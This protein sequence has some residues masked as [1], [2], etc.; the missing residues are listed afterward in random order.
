MRLQRVHCGFGSLPTSF[1][2]SKETHMFKVITAAAIS[3][4]A[5][6]AVASQPAQARG[7]AVAAGVIGGLAAGAIIGSEVNR[8]YYGGPGYYDNG[9]QAV[10]EC[11]I[12][13]RDFEDQ[14]GRLHVRRVCD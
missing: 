12:E 4:L 13:R 11:R 5:L 8:P 14:Y 3:A 1:H 2:H 7:G 9:Y 6:T 10:S